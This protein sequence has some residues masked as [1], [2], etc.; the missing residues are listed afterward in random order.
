MQTAGS[1]YD[2][3]IQSTVHFKLYDSNKHEI[4]YELLVYNFNT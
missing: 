2:V 3:K 4:F 1:A